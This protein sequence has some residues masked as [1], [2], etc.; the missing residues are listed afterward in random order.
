[1]ATAL[2]VLPLGAALLGVCLMLLGRLKLARMVSYLPLPVIGGTPHNTPQHTTHNSTPAL[3]RSSTTPAAM[4]HRTSP[5]LS[6]T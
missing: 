3:A 1:V 4:H 2:A 6:Q 5:P